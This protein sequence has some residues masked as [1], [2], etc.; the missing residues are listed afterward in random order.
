MTKFLVLYRS[1]ASNQEQ[2]TKTTPEQ[3]KAMMDAW[4]LW[5]KKVGPALLDVGA[6]IGA[7]ALLGGTP[8]PGHIGGYSIVQA[9]S[10]EAARQLFDGHPHFMAPN[11][12]IELLELLPMPGK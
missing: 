3:R 9:A 8:A 12:S 1:S 10:V 6:P 2:M 11:A 7:S 5:M 4:T